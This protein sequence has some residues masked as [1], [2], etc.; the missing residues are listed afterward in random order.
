[1]G[2]LFTDEEYQKRVHEVTIQDAIDYA[3]HNTIGNTTNNKG[4]YKEIPHPIS[5][6]TAN[7]L[8][9]LKDLQDRTMST[10]FTISTFKKDL[11]ILSKV[12]FVKII[13]TIGADEEQAIE[14]CVFAMEKLIPIL[15][16]IH[17]PSKDCAECT[18]E[19]FLACGDMELDKVR[20]CGYKP[21]K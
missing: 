4:E 2:K 11:E 19:Q 15:E 1:M 20:T 10:S 17:Q 7:Y 16:T 13:D 8:N 3:L 12:N 6:A 21:N 18:Q 14:N 9:L 5:M